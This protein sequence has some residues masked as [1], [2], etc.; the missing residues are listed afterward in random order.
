MPSGS[1]SGTGSMVSALLTRGLGFG[2]GGAGGV[3]QELAPPD[4]CG[5]SVTPLLP[6][7]GSFFFSSLLSRD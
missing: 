3:L 5:S 7:D 4:P 1:G 2:G 6:R